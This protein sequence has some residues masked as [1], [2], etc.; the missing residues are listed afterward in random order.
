M[1]LVSPNFFKVGNEEYSFEIMAPLYTTRPLQLMNEQSRRLEDRFHR[2]VEITRL[3]DSRNWTGAADIES[4]FMHDLSAYLQQWLEDC[5]GLWGANAIPERFEIPQAKVS[6]APAKHH[7]P[8][9]PVTVV[10]I[11]ARGS[12]DDSKI[13]EAASE[14]SFPASDSPQWTGLSLS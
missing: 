10:Y 13:V 14:D 11:G 1:R 4:W 3:S 12:T 5:F 6:A 7:C 2:T 9:F 8:E